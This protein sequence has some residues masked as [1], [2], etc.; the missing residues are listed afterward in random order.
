MVQLRLTNDDWA[1]PSPIPFPGRRD[2]AGSAPGRGPGRDAGRLD[3]MSGSA[4]REVEKALAR[5]QANINDLTE[6]L[7]AFDPIPMRAWRYDPEDDGPRA[8]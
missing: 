5:V 8:A 3:P 1:P 7:E 6:Q 4:E 2:D